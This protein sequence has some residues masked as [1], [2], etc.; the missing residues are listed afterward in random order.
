MHFLGDN[1]VVVLSFYLTPFIF[2]RRCLLVTPSHSN[3]HLWRDALGIT[4]EP[5]RFTNVGQT[6]NEHDDV[7]QLNAF[8]TVRLGP[9]T[10]GIHVRL[11]ILQ[12]NAPCLGTFLQHVRLVNALGATQDFL[13]ANEEI[14]RIGEF[15]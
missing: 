8:T 12:I 14:V 5:C 15:W 3:V 6:Q 7:F 13:A 1:N 2:I 11:N 4:G 9:M 10:E